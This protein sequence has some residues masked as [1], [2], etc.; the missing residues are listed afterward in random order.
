MRLRKIDTTLFF[1]IAFDAAPGVTYMSQLAD[2]ANAGMTVKQIVNV[3][4]TKAEFLS[5]YPNFF[6]NDQF[7]T[8]LVDNVVGTAAT[9][10]A[11]ASAVA[12]IAAAL[13]AGWSR[14]DV[15]YQVFTNLANKPTTDAT[16]GN[17]AKQM[18]NQVAYAQYYTE[19]LLT[20]TTNLTALRSVIASVTQDTDTSTTAIAKALAPADTYATS[21]LGAGIDTIITPSASV[22]TID[23]STTTLCHLLTPSQM[24]AVPTLTNWLLV[25]QLTNRVSVLQ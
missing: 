2:A 14:G 24:P 5:I 11:K 8:K 17:T 3:F 18:A 7:A 20:D 4:T 15:I 19:E 10:A 1:A 13:N 12:D 22:N 6:T 23:G 9:A 21:T 16:W 25:S